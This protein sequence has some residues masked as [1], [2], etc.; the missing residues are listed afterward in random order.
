[1][2]FAGNKY[3][4]I[5]QNKIEK[6][7][8]L[9]QK[10]TELEVIKEDNLEKLD[11]TKK[12]VIE[13]KS[14]LKDIIVSDNNISNELNENNNF[15]RRKFSEDKKRERSR[16]N[17][18]ESVNSCE[19]DRQ[20]SDED[21]YLSDVEEV[22]K[23]Q[24]KESKV[25][26]GFLDKVS[27][28]FS[29]IGEKLKKNNKTE[30]KQKK[31][32]YDLHKDKKQANMYKHEVDTNILTF[33]FNF[34]KEKVAFATGDPYYCTS[35][36]AILNKFSKI[37][38]KMDEKQMKE[39]DITAK[40][41]NFWKC[42]FCN[43]VSEFPNLEKEEIPTE[44]CIDY[45]IE[46]NSKSK[47]NFSEEKTIIYCFDTS[48]SMCVSEPLIG[49]HQI[50]GEYLSKY[51]NDLMKF[52]DGSN[53]HYGASSGKVTYVS[54]LQ[55][56]QAGIESYLNELSK[57]RP[58]NKIGLVTFNNGIFCIGDGSNSNYV[59]VEGNH[60]DDYSKIVELAEKCEP[61]INKPICETANN[62]IK[63]LYSIE[64]SGATALGPAILFS[65]NL[66]KNAPAGSKIILCT[67]GLANIGLGGM[68]E[69]TNKYMKN[70]QENYD[71]V[72]QFY[73]E[74][75]D[76][77]KSKGIIINILTFV[78]EESKIEILS[79]LT[80]KTGGEVIRVK[81]TEILNEFSNLMVN[82]IVATNVNISV[83]L[84]KALEFRNEDKN[85]LS[86]GNSDLIKHIGNATNETE[87]YTEY[88]VKR[89]DD[90]IK[91]NIDLDAIKSVYFQSIISYT[92]MEGNKCI[93]VITK[94]QELCTE[95]AKI[96]EQA[97]FNIFS[98]NAI[99]QCSKQA[100]KGDYRHAQSNAMAYKKVMKKNM[101]FD[102]Y[103]AKNAKENLI[104]FNNNFCELNDNLQK[105]QY[106]EKQEI[107]NDLFEGEEENTEKKWKTR[108]TKRQDVTSH[109]I[110]SKANTNS[111]KTQMYKK[112]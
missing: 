111:C 7:Q 39:I 4:Y 6:L 25:K 40:N 24:E 76:F 30:V 36:K 1:M 43:S 21:E 9:R 2:N 56:L 22:N 59:K 37:T 86:N 14:M 35:C 73:S 50:K 93:R 16:S 109:L 8:K 58:K 42:E 101:E 57:N 31:V 51:K 10:K 70:Y 103:N 5:S 38:M 12:N 47:Q 45:F 19:L 48:G 112:K 62:L 71:K 46:N 90:L 89:S 83:K 33:K 13:G 64:E 29:S 94:E 110:S 88:T 34:L 11:S 78:G 32:L 98:V 92:N 65:V 91:L 95:K 3:T 49:N 20:Y 41:S 67:D 28:M 69:I 26:T 84:H 53:Q 100:K 72:N 81:P 23:I 96:Q 17:S 87:L 80:E 74:I 52:S 97:D 105:L 85:N 79:Q 60:L 106:E 55:C 99:Q 82:E 108:Q 77:A 104:M 15:R 18:C 61:L 27:N 63:L 75:G 68:D 107:S 44:E 102:N 66:I 54:R